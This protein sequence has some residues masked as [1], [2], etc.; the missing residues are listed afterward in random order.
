MLEIFYLEIK[1]SLPK[2]EGRKNKMRRLIFPRKNEKKNNFFKSKCE[3][4][5][6]KNILGFF[7]YLPSAE[8]TL[9][10]K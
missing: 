7:Y 1:S 10:K 8:K 4:V 9:D 3:P 6:G 5:A 2:T